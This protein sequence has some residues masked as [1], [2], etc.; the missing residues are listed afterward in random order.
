M[1]CCLN[2]FCTGVPTA[3]FG[4]CCPTRHS[5]CVT[6]TERHVPPML[7][8]SYAP[9]T[10]SRHPTSDGVALLSAHRLRWHTHGR[11]RVATWH[12]HASR[13]RTLRTP[14]HCVS[15]THAPPHGVGD[16]SA[17]VLVHSTMYIVL[18]RNFARVVSALCGAPCSRNHAA[19]G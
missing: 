9:R 16:I 10:Y 12:A 14:P 11:M 8:P 1:K 15:V 18:G 4:V 7:C 19:H 17:D 3:W 2:F 5:A 6:L 13:A